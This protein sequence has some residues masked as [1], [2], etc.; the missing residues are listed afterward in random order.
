MFSKN[1]QTTTTSDNR[2]TTRSKSASGVPSIISPDMT[3]TGDISST[4]DVQIDGAVDGDVKAE[5]L[6]VGEQGTVNGTVRVDKVRILGRINGEL[7]AESATLLASAKVIGDVV[8]E[9]LSIE[10]GAMIEGHCRRRNQAD[11][12]EKGSTAR[13]AD[14][15]KET[16]AK[17]ASSNEVKPLANGRRHS[18]ETS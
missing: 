1:R 11:V 13:P 16:P 7:H 8:H 17:V 4:G 6:T 3:I 15:G 10:A 5:T 14:S 9:S 2:D 18:A 12:T